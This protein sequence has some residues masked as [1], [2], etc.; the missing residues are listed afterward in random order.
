MVDFLAILFTN[1]YPPQPPPAYSTEPDVNLLGNLV[2]CVDGLIKFPE[3]ILI[4]VFAPIKF[5]FK[6]PS[7]L[8]KCFRSRTPSENGETIDIIGVSNDGG[9]LTW[10]CVNYG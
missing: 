2:G 10:F 1:I 3:I 7:S 6:P 8:S 4:L 9:V 5:L